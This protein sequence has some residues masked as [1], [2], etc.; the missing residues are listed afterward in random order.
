MEK[1]KVKNDLSSTFDVVSDV[2][3]NTFLGVLISEIVP[4]FHS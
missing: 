3:M 1:V 4:C 2:V